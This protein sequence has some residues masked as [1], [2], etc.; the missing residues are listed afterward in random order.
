MGGEGQ[1]SLGV[2]LTWGPLLQEV[3]LFS[4]WLLLAG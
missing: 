4:T 3:T 1:L 2:V